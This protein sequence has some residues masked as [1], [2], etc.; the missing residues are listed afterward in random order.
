[1]KHDTHSRRVPEPVGG[2]S[3]VAR[4]GDCIYTIAARTGHAWQ[5]LWD[6]PR[7]QAL[8]QARRH[9]GVL[10][11]G[12]RVFVPELKPKS[13]L[14]P[15]G[16]RHRIVIDGQQVPLRL[17]LCD[18]DGAPIVNAAYQL[19]VASQ[20]LPLTTNDDG[21][22][23]ALVPSLAEEA[24]LRDLATGECFILR[25]GHLDPADA[26]SA[27]RKRLA[28][29][30]YAPATDGGVEGEIDEQARLCL[31]EFGEDARVDPNATWDEVVARLAKRAPWAA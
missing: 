9:P 7:N 19:E 21:C 24:R 15:A 10:L 26:A 23:E 27:I 31:E 14:L 17:R 22:L 5:T 18:A 6:H 8:R 28:N 29:L 1:M 11:P 13:I 12:D 3:Y 25:I 4:Q 20:Q 2:D 30:G 16:R